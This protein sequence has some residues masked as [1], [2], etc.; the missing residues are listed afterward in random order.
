MKNKTLNNSFIASAMGIYIVG[1]MIKYSEIR[2]FEL[3][4]ILIFFGVFLTMIISEIILDA[5]IKNKN[6]KVQI[7]NF[8]RLLLSAVLIYFCVMLNQDLVKE[9]I[10]YFKTFIGK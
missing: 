1:M 3:K 5:A 6:T 9:F 2:T 4:S 8:I 10:P 7:A